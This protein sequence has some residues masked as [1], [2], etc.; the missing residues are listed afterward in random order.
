VEKDWVKPPF[1]IQSVPGITG[2]LSAESRNLMFMRETAD[3]LFGKDYIWSLLGAGRH[4]MNLCTLSA[5]MGGNVRVGL[6]D[7]IFLGKGKL[8][9]S[10]ADQVHKI[11]HILE[12]LSLEIAKPAEAR[13]M[14]GLKGGD[15]VGF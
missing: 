1:F 10:N 8:A 6:E 15:Q 14:L 4:Q 9:A 11:R 2:G 13:A 5:I 12:E 3:R 7:K